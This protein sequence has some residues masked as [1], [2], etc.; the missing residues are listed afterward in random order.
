MAFNQKEQPASSYIDPRDGSTKERVTELKS[1][2]YELSWNEAFNQKWRMNTIF[3]Y[4]TRRADRPDHYG[5]ELRNGLGVSDVF[6][7]RLHTGFLNEKKTDLKDDRGYFHILWA[8]TSLFWEFHF[9]YSLELSYGLTLEKEDFNDDRGVA[10]VGTDSYGLK[11]NYK[12]LD[13]IFSLSYIY[14]ATNTNYK[15][16]TFQGGITWSI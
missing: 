6:T 4:G 11:L 12:G 1:F 15:S 7:L 16:H 9:D 13:S 8:E 14:R 10:K 3:F 5:A 2:R